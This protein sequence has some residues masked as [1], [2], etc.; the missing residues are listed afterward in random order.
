MG[1]GTQSSVVPP[2][3]PPPHRQQWLCISPHGGHL[4]GI[5]WEIRVFL[6]NS[7]EKSVWR[8]KCQWL[9]MNTVPRKKTTLPSLSPVGLSTINL[10]CHFPIIHAPSP[11]YPPKEIYMYIHHWSL[12]S[13]VE[14]LRVSVSLNS[15]SLDAPHALSRVAVN[16]P[17]YLFVCFASHRQNH[18]V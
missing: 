4:H 7:I 13:E 2:L 9:G 14:S 11:P 1:L 6:I 12:L 3:G 17:F 8:G 16:L 18:A 5:H 15:E 10:V